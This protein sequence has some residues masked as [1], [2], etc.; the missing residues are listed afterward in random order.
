MQ[1][2]YLQANGTICWVGR[3]NLRLSKTDRKLAIKSPWIVATQSGVVLDII[4][5]KLSNKA[6]NALANSLF[7]SSRVGFRASFYSILIV[8]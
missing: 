7:S 8:I 5:I 1:L 3:T 2:I 4:R 6:S